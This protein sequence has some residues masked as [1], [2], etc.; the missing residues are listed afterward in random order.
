MKLSFTGNFDIDQK[1]LL[2]LDL[3]TIFNIYNISSDTRNFIL[4]S[5]DKILKIHLN[6]K[7]CI[8]YFLADVLKL[9]DHEFIR[10][11]FTDYNSTFECYILSEL[12]NM[13]EFDNKLMTETYIYLVD[14]SI[15]LD[16]KYDLLNIFKSKLEYKKSEYEGNNDIHLRR[17][18]MFYNIL[19]AK[20]TQYI[21][22]YALYKEKLNSNLT[23]SLIK[24]WYVYKDR[25]I[26]NTDNHNIKYQN[27]L[28]IDNIIENFNYIKYC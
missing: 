16:Y 3:K 22:H 21:S 19:T 14:G 5:F 1:I 18:K 4:Q 10:K 2:L 8:D 13:L 23:D 24:L 27:I 11:I 26:Y 6:N 17:L 28:F 7:K 20:I 15:C 9:G 12:M 25:I